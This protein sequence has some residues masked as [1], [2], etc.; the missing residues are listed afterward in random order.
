MRSAQEAFRVL[1]PGGRL[2]VAV[3]DR[4]EDNTFAH[5]VVAALLS[6]AGPDAF[7]LSWQDELADGR[8]ERWL[9]EAGLTDVVSEPVS[10]TMPFADA[11]ALWERASDLGPLATVFAAR[12]DADRAA[13]RDHLLAT[14]A[15]HRGADGSYAVPVSGRVLT[16]VAPAAR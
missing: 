11:H 4:A 16:A 13:A 15:E 14:L 7:D 2:A 3:W 9:R 8:R 12:D 10:W 5:A 1:R 6:V